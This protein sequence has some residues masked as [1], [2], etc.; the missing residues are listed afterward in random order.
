[1][2]SLCFGL[3]IICSVWIGAAQTVVNSK[4][5]LSTGN[6]GMTQWQSTNESQVCIFCHTP[7][8]SIPAVKPLWNKSLP[9]NTTFSIYSSP[10][11]DVTPNGNFAGT[12]SLLCLS[13]HDGVTAM[14]ALANNSTVG[15]PVMAGG[16]S[17]LGQ[18]YYPGS[19]FAE[20]PGANIGEGYGGVVSNRLSN[21][22]PVN[23]VYDPSH[24]DV[25]KGSLH[26]PDTHPSGIGGTVTQKMLYNHVL[27]CSSCHNP[28]NPTHRPF[29]K[30]ANT[31]SSLCLTCHNK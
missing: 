18:V 29:L 16:Y 20:F 15:Q 30:K 31:N 9:A 10:T 28:H 26:N 27:E 12:L 13:C 17:R 1:M 14:N 19:I 6:S 3:G 4:H 22:H 11:M 24:P 5:D 25:A 7:H 21:D 2:R 8:T 23:F